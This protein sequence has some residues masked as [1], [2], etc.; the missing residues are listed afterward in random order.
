MAIMVSVSSGTR[1]YQELK[2]E[3]K[4][5]ALTTMIKKS[6]TVIRRNSDDSE[7]EEVI[8]LRDCVPGK[9]KLIILNYIIK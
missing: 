3:N 4:T 6:I 8:D 5:L 7:Y 2:N 9:V 1:F